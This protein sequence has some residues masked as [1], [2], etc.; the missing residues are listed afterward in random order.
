MKVKLF[1]LLI[2]AALIF[3]SNPLLGNE[4]DSLLPLSD[5]LEIATS[6]VPGKVI[7]AELRQ[8]LYE[9]I[10]ITEEG[11]EERVF[12]DPMEGTI[13]EKAGLSLD[14]AIKIALEKVPGEIIKIEYER[15]KYEFKI[16]TSEGDK[17]EVYIDSRSG[18]VLKIES[19]DD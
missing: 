13:I 14:E 19:H 6:K 4:R 15:G 5:V 17:K 3:P 12:I 8:G 16:R 10:I 7:R 1:L 2:S 11:K 18:K 9:V